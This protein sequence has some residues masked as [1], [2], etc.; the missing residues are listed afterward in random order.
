MI[1]EWMQLELDNK[2][3][4]GFNAPDPEEIGRLAAQEEWE[5][6]VGMHDRSP[7]EISAYIKALFLRLSNLATL[8]LFERGALTEGDYPNLL[9][10]NND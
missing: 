7:E 9:E 8:H 1:D 4:D 3:Y 5:R 10:R 2:K 6:R